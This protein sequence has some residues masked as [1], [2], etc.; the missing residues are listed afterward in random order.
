M[1]GDAVEATLGTGAMLEKVANMRMLG[2]S[3]VG[4]YLRVNEWI[5]RRLP[6]SMTALRPVD[7]YGRFLHSLASLH[8]R[9]EM[10]LG[11]FFFRNRPELEL[12]RRLSEPIAARRPVKI[13][14]LGCSNGAEVYSIRWALRSILP[15]RVAI[16]AVDVSAAA[17]E[18]ARRGTYSTG[19]SELVHEPIC[20]FM[21]PGE[22]A[23]M[24]DREGERLEIKAS[25]R[26]GI[27]WHAGDAADARM[28]D[29]LGPQDIAIA[30]RFLC[31]MA[32][33]DAERCLRSLVRLVAPGGHLFVSGVDLDVRTKVARDLGWMPA[34][35]LLEDVHDGDRSLRHDWPCKYWGLEPL[36]KRRPD[37]AIRYA[38]AFQIG[39]S[40]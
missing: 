27:E 17:L 1:T 8:A 36:D 37:W 16:H 38:S 25:L 26:E 19:V 22:I 34:R 15:G 3:P 6:R 40:R 2:K 31:H 9:R 24:F 30:N 12:I 39:W 28:R 7:S 5:W 35:E 11:T 32:P 29:A 33:P 20:A 21:T 10:Y 14:V 13:A 4:A 23:G 18:C